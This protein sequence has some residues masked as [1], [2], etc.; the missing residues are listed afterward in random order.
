MGALV[1]VGLGL[2]DENDVSLRGLEEIRRADFVFAELYTSLMKGLKIEKLENL[3]GKKI[4]L[5]TRKMLEEENGRQILAVAK[6]GRAVFL[7]PG[8]PLIATTHVNLRIKARELG[9]ETFVVHGA[10]IVSAAIGMS[11]LQNYKFGRSVTIPF[12][13]G[14]IVSETPYNVVKKNLEAGLHTL[15]FLDIRA[16]EK[17][18]MTIKEALETLLVTE[19]RRRESIITYST[20]VV[21]I[22]RAGSMN[23]VVKA[24]L[25]GEALDYDFGSPPHTLVFPGKLHFVEAEALIKLANAPES[26]KKLIG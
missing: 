7:V 26:V 22:A 8:D 14:C 20:L 1:F 5:V 9:I 24:G 11:G 23:P 4:V 16:E 17:R 19:K 25:L 18:F 3:A 10:S 12:T 2:H 6:K 21:G 15:C 13:D